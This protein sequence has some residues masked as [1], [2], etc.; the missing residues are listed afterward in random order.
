MANC[1]MIGSDGG[2]FQVPFG[3]QAVNG[4]D[5]DRSD[6]IHGDMKIFDDASFYFFS[7]GVPDAS[8]KADFNS[9]GHVFSFLI[10]FDGFVV[11]SCQFL[12]FLRVH[13]FGKRRLFLP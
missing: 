6:G 5:I 8:F 13:Q 4:E 9:M 10:Q 12:D 3:K 11:E 7:E 2:F 1:W